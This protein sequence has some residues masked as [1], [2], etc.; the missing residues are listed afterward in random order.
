[1]IFGEYQQARMRNEAA[2]SSGELHTLAMRLR[3]LARRKAPGPLRERGGQVIEKTADCFRSRMPADSRLNCPE[4]G[5]NMS[6]CSVSGVD[7]DCCWTCHSLWLDCGELPRL[8]GRA[9]RIP[10]RRLHHRASVRFCPVC[11]EVMTEYQFCRGHN[12]L[13]DSCSSGHG[14]CLQDGELERVLLG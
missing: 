8:T 10:G 12:L 4:C 1:M 9:T 13:I 11:G 3:E 5:R 6:V 14:V 2:S 7:I